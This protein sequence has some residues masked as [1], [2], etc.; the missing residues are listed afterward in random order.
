[1]NIKHSGLS[2]RELHFDQFKSLSNFN[3][4]FEVI[5]ENYL[6]TQ[7]ERRE[8]LQDLAKNRFL[9]LHG[10]TS[11]IGS[12]DLLDEDFFQKLR[13]LSRQTNAKLHSDHLCWTRINQKSTF[14]LLPVPRTK[15]MIDHIGLRVKKISDNLGNDFFLE[16]ISSYFSYEIDEMP[17]LEF[18]IELYNQ[19]QVRFLLDVNNLYVNSKNFN[20]DANHFI[21]NL[22][23]KSVAAFHLG[24]HEDFGSFLFDTH[25]APVIEPVKSLFLAAEKRFGEKP[26]FLERDENIPEDV[27]VLISELSNLTGQVL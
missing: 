17:E 13:I 16:N 3:F 19:H 11:N 21:E 10:V 6:F 9:H 8:I 2:L 5:F 12:L 7:G 20:F 23:V 24:G 25:S 18:M 1:M 26:T 4:A 15:N 22:P 27:Q 14:E